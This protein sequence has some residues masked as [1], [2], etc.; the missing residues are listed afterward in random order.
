V[1]R[2]CLPSSKREKARTLACHASIQVL[3]TLC[4]SCLSLYVYA[5]GSKRSLAQLSQIDEHGDAKRQRPGGAGGVGGRG[6]ASAGL[7]LASGGAAGASAA[8]VNR[9]SSERESKIESESTS[10]A[11]ASLPREELVARLDEYLSRGA[12]VELHSHLLGMGSADFWVSRIM[13]TYLPRVLAKDVLWRPMDM[14]P[15]AASGAS[16]RQPQA[17]LAVQ[18]TAR[19]LGPR[20]ATRLVLDLAHLHACRTNMIAALVDARQLACNNDHSNAAQLALQQ[21]RAKIIEQ[22]DSLVKD[23]SSLLR[24]LEQSHTADLATAERTIATASSTT[25]PASTQPAGPR[26]PASISG[27]EALLRALSSSSLQVLTD[28]IKDQH[29]RR[30]TTFDL[31]RLAFI[32]EHFT[33]DVVYSEE[34]LCDACGIAAT[35]NSALRRAQLEST[36]NNATGMLDFSTKVH[37]YVI[38]NTRAREFQLVTGVTNHDIISYLAPLSFGGLAAA[39]GRAAADPSTTSRPVGAAAVAEQAATAGLPTGM[40]AVR[41]LVRNWFEFLANDGGGPRDTD[42]SA[43][44][45]GSFTPEFFPRRFAAKDAIYEQRLEVLGILLNCVLGRYGDAGVQN[46]ELSLGFKDGTNV[47]VLRVIHECTFRSLL[48]PNPAGRITTAHPQSDAAPPASTQRG[49]GRGTSGPTSSHETAHFLAVPKAMRGVQPPWRRW[50]GAGYNDKPPN[51]TCKLLLA[52]NRGACRGVPVEFDMSPPAPTGKVTAWQY[53]SSPA[54]AQAALGTLGMWAKANGHRFDAVA[55]LVARDECLE[56]MYPKEVKK[57]A[58]PALANGKTRSWAR[59]DTA[60]IMVG[61]V[62]VIM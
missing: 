36:F 46:V 53:V 61:T 4:P 56:A 54:E 5:A 13:M 23:P 49:S 42:V 14:P 41:A 27:R 48:L 32:L 33:D 1:Q 31:E 3:G 11:D 51:Q 35:P 21:F 30:N 34:R 45:R 44:Y 55:K 17:S 39:S 59:R 40:P 12:L 18:L 62:T 7:V 60:G 19:G 10:P 58:C 28:D 24:E 9:G 37:P 25:H 57:C 38:Y 22:L 26:P 47:D 43:L 16:G 15:A 52:L 6:A 29:T 8:S 50:L 2:C 20:P